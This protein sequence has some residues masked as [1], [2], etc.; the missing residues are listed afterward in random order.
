M[1]PDGKPLSAW[2]SFILT[3]PGWCKHSTRYVYDNE[4]VKCLFMYL[5]SIVYLST[6]R[7]KMMEISVHA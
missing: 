7:D 6:G 1:F 5:N 4:Y 3:T 2:T